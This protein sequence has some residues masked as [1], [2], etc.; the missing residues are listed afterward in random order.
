MTDTTIHLAIS[1]D[2]LLTANQRPHWAVKARK[3][4]VIRDMAY[5]M[6]LHPKRAPMSKVKCH[7]EVTWPDRRDRDAPNLYPVFKAAID[8]FVDAGLIQDDCDR[9]MKELRITASEKTRH[10]KGVAAYL[11]FEL[12]E[13]Q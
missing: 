1:R 7:V 13:V 10:T 2:V 9:I 4:K 8:G 12:S 6:A 11:K 5:I 3:T